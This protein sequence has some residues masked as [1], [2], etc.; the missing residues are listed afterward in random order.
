[1]EQSKPQT[2]GILLY[3]RDARLVETRAWV[4]QKAGFRVLTALDPLHLQVRG[5]EEAIELFL[6]C[7]SLD[8]EARS[9]ALAL[10][11]SNWPRAKRLV[12]APVSLPA[13]IDPTE[14]VFQAIEGPGKLVIAIRSLIVNGPASVC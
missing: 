1:M 5:M 10:I 11:H 6:L 2:A 3:G 13:G 7:D 8:Q 9:H 4:L 12:L 14:E